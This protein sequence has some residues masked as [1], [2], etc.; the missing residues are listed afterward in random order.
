[1]QLAQLYVTWVR[2]LEVNQL[3]VADTFFKTQY[4]PSTFYNFH[5]IYTPSS[6]GSSIFCEI[7]VSIPLALADFSRN[8]D[9]VIP[10]LNTLIL[11]KFT[12]SD[13]TS[14]NTFWRAHPGIKCLELNQSHRAKP[15][16]HK[17][18]VLGAWA[19]ASFRAPP[20]DWLAS[21]YKGLQF[22]DQLVSATLSRQNPCG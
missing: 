4:Q 20:K 1:M 12:V 22:L 19:V 14:S 2:Q 9:C 21:L 7:E 15:L 16:K 17:R 6:F 5:N 11:D 8:F 10:N 18:L 13:P 3:Q